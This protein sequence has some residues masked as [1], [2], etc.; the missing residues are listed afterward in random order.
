MENTVKTFYRQKKIF[1]VRLELI[2]DFLLS[3]LD[4]IDRTYLGD[5]LMKSSNQR[6]HFCWCLD[7]TIKLFE[8][9]DIRVQK[10]QKLEDFLYDLFLKYYY[11]L[12][13]TKTNLEDFKIRLCSLLSYSMAKKDT[14]LEEIAIYNHIFN[15]SMGDYLLF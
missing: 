10:T 2:K 4:K 8:N 15:Q 1:Y 14:Q 11:N 13:K 7:F 6:E 5:D 9:E 3:L 12:K